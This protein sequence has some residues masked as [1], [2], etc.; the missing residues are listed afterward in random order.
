MESTMWWVAV[1]YAGSS[2]VSTVSAT[3]AERPTNNWTAFRKAAKTSPANRIRDHNNAFQL[4][5]VKLDSIFKKPYFLFLNYIKLIIM[6][7]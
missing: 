5:V 3:F 2:V 4:V 1:T 7:F 6:I